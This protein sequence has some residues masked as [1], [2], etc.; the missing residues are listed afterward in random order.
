VHIDNDGSH[1]VLCTLRYGTCNQTVGGFLGIPFRCQHRSE[2]L[3]GQSLEQTVCTEHEPVTGLA[4]Y[5]G[6]VHL[7]VRAHA[8]SPGQD[9]TV[10]VRRASSLPRVPARMRSATTVWS[11]VIWSKR[12]ARKW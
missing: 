8:E 9:M 6:M 5:P 11:R 1:V 12:P 7:E 2:F 10:G 4:R 3:G